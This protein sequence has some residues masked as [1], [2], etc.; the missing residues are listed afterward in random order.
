M[1]DEEPAI[2]ASAFDEQDQS[3]RVAV[4]LFQ[5]EPPLQ[6]LKV[7]ES[8]L[9]LDVTEQFGASNVGIPCA[10][11]AGILPYRRLVPPLQRG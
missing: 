11:V 1:L 7:V 9:R 10:Q 2:R 6:G 3:S 8:N 4:A 5:F